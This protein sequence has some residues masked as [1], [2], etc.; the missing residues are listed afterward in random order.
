M[1]AAGM[2]YLS[3]ERRGDH[4]AQSFW[5]MVQ[6]GFDYFQRTKELPVITVDAAGSYVITPR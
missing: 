1:D 5:K 3:V 2:E 6:P 4:D